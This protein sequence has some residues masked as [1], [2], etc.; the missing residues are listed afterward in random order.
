MHPISQ[1]LVEY[2]STLYQ[3]QK[4]HGMSQS[5]LSRSIITNSPIAHMRVSALEQFARAFNETPET[6]LRKLLDYEEEAKTEKLKEVL[7][8]CGFGIEVLEELEETGK[9]KISMQHDG[10]PALMD[11][12]NE[13]TEYVAE[14]SP[15][16]DFIIISKY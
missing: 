12:I 2:D 13:Q 16:T 8:Q 9:T 7:E 4:Y 1:L 3:L 10:T 14:L 5:S 6:I 11:A 15:S